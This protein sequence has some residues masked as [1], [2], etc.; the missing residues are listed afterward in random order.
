MHDYEEVFFRVGANV[1]PKRDVL[2]TEGPLDHLDHAPTLQFVGGK[3]GI[4]ATHKGPAEGAREWPPEIEMS[5]EVRRWSTGAGTSTGSADRPARTARSV[6][7]CGDCYVV[8]MQTAT[9]ESSGSDREAS[10]LEPDRATTASTS[11]ADPLAGRLRRRR[12]LPPRRPVVSWVAVAVGG[13]IALVFGFLW[14]RDLTAGHCAGR[15]A[16]APPGAGGRAAA[17]VPR[18]PRGGRRFPRNMF[19]E[20]RRSASAP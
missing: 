19:L 16:E 8:D 5:A 17:A 18:A 6:R 20:A 14:V 9:F 2:L 10:R 12:R 7:R 15:A 1:D 11:R 13:A 3:I 4:D